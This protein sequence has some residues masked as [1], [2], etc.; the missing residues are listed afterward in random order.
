MHILY[1]RHCAGSWA[2]LPHPKLGFDISLKLL[3][4]QHHV[5]QREHS[6]TCAYGQ[7]LGKGLT[8]TKVLTLSSVSFLCQ[9]LFLGKNSGVQKEVCKGGGTISKISVTVLL[10]EPD[11]K[12]NSHTLSLNLSV[13][14]FA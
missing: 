7:P 11:V 10:L 5:S 3:L 14:D 8:F 1:V 2:H 4:S 6:K 9:F 13:N 12:R